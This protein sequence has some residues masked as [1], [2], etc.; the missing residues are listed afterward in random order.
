M[1]KN[2]DARIKNGEKKTQRLQS[3]WTGTA[4]ILLL[5]LFILPAAAQTTK[6][7]LQNASLE[8]V[9][10]EIQK[11]TDYQVF[12]NAKTA[13]SI[14]GLELNFQNAT[15]EEILTEALK[16]TSLSYAIT[17][18]TI[19]IR[20]K[21]P[22]QSQQ[23]YL[24]ITGTVKDRK[25]EP[26]PGASIVVKGTTIGVSADIDGNFA[27][28][29]PS[30]IAAITVSFIGYQPQDVAILDT[31][32]S[33]T[34]KFHVVLKED[35]NEMEEVVVTGYQT[36]S[37]ERAT[38]SFAK[39]SNETLELRRMDNLSNMLEGQI[40][41][42]TNGQIRGIT[43]MNAVAKPM[44]VIDGFPVENT[45]MNRSGETTENMPDLNPEDIESVTVLK[46][47]AAASIYGARAA[48]GVIVITTKKAKKG[49]TEISA[50]ATF[51]IQ[52]YSFYTGNL[53]DAA[54]VVEM[55]RQWAAQSSALQAG[56]TSAQNK[57]NELRNDGVYPS[58][59]IDIL[60][61][62]YTGVISA[63]EAN[64]KLDSLASTGYR[65]YDQMTKHT[66]R[67]PFY[68]QYNMRIG[69]TSDRNSI[70]ASVTYWRN[71][72]EDIYSQD[73]KLSLNLTNYLN[74]T[75]WLDI[76]LGVYLKYGK[77]TGQTYDP[78]S[79]GYSF[80]PYDA[81]VAEDG[82]YVSTIS[83]LN[84]EERENLAK[85]NLY[86][87]TIIPMKELGLRLNHT[88]DFSSRAYAKI[89]LTFT[90]W[91]NYHVMYQ[92]E[93]G[94][95]RLNNLQET[96]SYSTQS[97]IN[98]FASIGQNNQLVYN[99]PDG[100]IYRTEDH[101]STAYNFRQQLN[102]N[103]TFNDKHSVVWIV[104]NEIRN[105]KLEY[106]DN[107]L[108]GYDSKLLTWEN[109]DAKTL[110][111]GVAG[112]NGR[113]SLASSNIT[114]KQEII[115]R[116][117][118]FYS[119]ASY[120]FDDRYSVSGS[121][122]WDRSNLWGTNAK[123]QNKPLWS[124]GFSW[125]INK[126]AFFNIEK[127]NMLKIRGSYGIGGNIGRNTAPYL[128]AMYYQDYTIGELCGMVKTP[129]NEDIRWEKTQTFNVG[130][131]F[132][133]FN[134][135]LNGS[136]D[137]YTKKSDDLLA[138]INGSPTQGF[139]YG[140]LTTN[141][142]AMTNKGFEL[143]LRGDI[144]R[145]GAFT[146]NA[147]LLYAYNK[148][149]VTKVN[150]KAP[151]YDFQIKYPT[152]YPV[153]DR[154]FN[155]I[156]GYKWAGLNENGD[157]QV[158]NADNEIVSTA[159]TDLEAI[160]YF[161]TTV[162]VHSGTFTNIFSY[163]NFE[164]SVMLLFEAGHKIRETNIPQINM[165]DGRIVTTSKDISKRWRQAGD[166]LKTDVPRLL[167]SDDTE[168]Y[169][170]YRS[171]LYRYSDKFIYDASNIKVRNISV[172]YRMPENICKRLMASS[173][174]LQFNIENVATLAFDKKAH[175]VLKGKVKPNYV[176]S[177]NVNF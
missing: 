29:V 87:E 60:L 139:G 24:E 15:V 67:N 135:R 78:K 51:T 84:K 90:P 48:N 143:T 58:A 177:I 33:K 95:K 126:E 65:Y 91:L 40:A 114:T 77:E 64:R 71:R 69:K 43:T 137:V 132:A 11:K 34:H 36:I 152:S 49:K 7:Q 113:V 59:G 21:Q 101:N 52:P 151:G 175:Y 98:R 159:V 80:L 56:G 12:Y 133:A 131:D 154:A 176:C 55:Q 53:T 109:I 108:Y 13:Q 165:G 140:D 83:Q 134:Y 170:T 73:D 150:I 127:I 61:N 145:K 30:D 106:A 5:H 74:V 35:N 167:F 63:N 92:H 120:T 54:D 76:D 129:P 6:I 82:S 163:R 89:K 16:G 116:F 107:T 141:N 153:M 155:G 119:N 168:N 173:V 142:G 2:V 39:V 23:K 62:Q 112:I 158:Y 85:Y 20:A 45:S 31:D 117:V 88:K 8:Q 122:R 102:L 157:P 162:P 148:N 121:I 97:I 94:T 18:S 4:L 46:D 96:E 1:K 42:Y 156:Y 160:Q 138:N 75:S 130:V 27:I 147:T 26:L 111:A 172:A 44:V 25:N 9:L 100:D 144:L 79:P 103:K 37:K 118:S 81:L 146:W 136:I 110:A 14:K 104:G 68:Q 10:K 123:N 22:Q 171:D 19:V 115:N 125:L 99:I 32:P 166:H 161:G 70:N 38:G 57:A 174:K 3:L 93:T 17:G 128:V 149:K 47:A 105:T 50:S 66:K 86:D 41:G 72:S 164:A 28:R 124:V 169:N